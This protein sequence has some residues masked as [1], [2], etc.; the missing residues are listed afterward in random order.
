[1][2]LFYVL[3]N[4]FTLPDAYECPEHMKKPSSTK[5]PIF[6]SYLLISG[7]IFILLY[8]PCL[9]AI[10]RAKA[11]TPAYQLMLIIAILD[12]I[13]LTVGSLIAG[14]TAINGT[15][16]CQYPLFSYI[17][18][19]V[20]IGGWMTDC[21]ACILL[22]IERCV[23]VNPS[24]FLSVLFKKNP[25][26][27]IMACIVTYGVYA[28]FFTNPPIF[29]PE[30]SVYLF[31][32]MIGKD[33]SLYTN[34][35]HAMNNPVV[36]VSTTALYFYLCYYLI[37]KFGYSTSMWIYRSKRQ[38]ILQG[39]ILCFFHSAA[40]IIYE[41]MQYFSPPIWLILAGQVTWQISSGCL[42]IVYLTL[43][44][45]IRNSVIK[46]LIPK[47][48]RIRWGM[49][50]GV[51]EHLELEHAM[52]SAGNV[53]VAVTLYILCFIAIC[54]IKSS[55]PVYQ[56]MFFIAI[57]D[58]IAI[59][60]GSL[61]LGYL[62]FHGIFFCQCP[63]FFFIIGSLAMFTWLFNCVSCIILAIERCSEVNPKFFLSFL[64]GKK[65]FRVVKTLVFIYGINGLMFSKPVIF[66]PEYTSFIYDPLIGK[67][68]SLYQNNWLA[69]NN[70]AI[71]LSTTTLYFYLC[72]Y[73]LLKYRYS[74]SMWLYKSTRQIILQGV[75]M[76]FFH[77]A[78]ACI[79]EYMAYFTPTLYVIVAGEVV[80][81]L[82]C[83][84]LSVVYLTL[85]RTIRNTV[86]KMVIP[87]SIR[88]KYGWHIGVEE[89]LAVE[90]A[91][92]TNGIALVNASGMP[93]KFDNFFVN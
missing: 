91:A 39:V 41:Y 81:Q 60:V 53:G 4:S 23:E 10:I 12:I 2:T 65:V 31:D 69:G 1:M 37:F 77:S 45:T 74:T 61:I 7:T 22:A 78:A 33:P 62:T 68:P 3:T 54:K 32:P 42:S 82:A 64:F 86:V 70:F 50:I 58:I 72:Y 87:K 44:R 5:W 56:L 63:L 38:I 55:A 25:F 76:C 85:N 93:V 75:V 34:L 84:C 59:I 79:Y 20:G 27:V 66:S 40:A 24:F 35:A 57:F 89:H 46:M 6:G 17:V 29:N 49:H 71:A 14:I 51:E 11:W 19:A 16:F 88:A 92:E 26:R 52:D 43:N 8:L 9:I 28:L 13:S 73:L 36:A 21:L 15:H 80:Y 48:L 67:D 90:Q 18:G 83:S 30:Y 47:S